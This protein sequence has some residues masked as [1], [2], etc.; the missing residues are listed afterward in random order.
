MGLFYV[1]AA[2]GI[3]YISVVLNGVRMV[4][5]VPSPAVKPTTQ[6]TDPVELFVTRSAFNMVKSAALR[7]TAVVR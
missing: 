6:E 7:V 1:R 2:I 5:L 3:P 4:L